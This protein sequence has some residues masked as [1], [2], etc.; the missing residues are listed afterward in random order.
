MT[1]FSRKP[2]TWE[3]SRSVLPVRS[4]RTVARR[5]PQRLPFPFVAAFLCAGCAAYGQICSQPQR[6]RHKAR[7]RTRLPHSTIVDRALSAS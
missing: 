7:L 1:K 6:L 2:S 4:L 3:V 5:R